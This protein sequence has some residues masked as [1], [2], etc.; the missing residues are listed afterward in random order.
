MT[1]REAFEEW[2]VTQ[3]LPLNRG[4][5]RSYLREESEIAWRAWQAATMA[6]RKR[7]AKVCDEQSV[8]QK[9]KDCPSAVNGW[10]PDQITFRC[11]AAI[12]E[13]P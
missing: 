5:V 3:F 9:N 2:A 11:A 1:D 13:A 10:W 6:E 7:A 12:R 4:T 8:S